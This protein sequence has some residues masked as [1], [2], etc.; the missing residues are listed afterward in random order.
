V[1]GM[2][3]YHLTILILFALVCGVI[4]AVAMIVHYRRRKR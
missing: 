1:F 3:Y 2:D 4:P